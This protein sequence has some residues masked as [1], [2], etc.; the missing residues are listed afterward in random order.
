MSYN[1]LHFD[2]ADFHL[3]NVKLLDL[4]GPGTSIRREL[5]ERPHEA[6]LLV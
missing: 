2:F 5:K 4:S 6:A 3:F 1:V